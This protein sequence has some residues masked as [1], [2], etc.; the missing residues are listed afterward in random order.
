MDP[1]FSDHKALLS[2]TVTTLLSAEPKISLYTSG[3][4]TQKNKTRLSITTQEKREQGI[5]E[6]I[7]G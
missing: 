2:N 5:H 4:P 1:T 7:T 3:L 6:V